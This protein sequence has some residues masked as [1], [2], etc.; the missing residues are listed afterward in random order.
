MHYLHVLVFINMK[1]KVALYRVFCYIQVHFKAGLTINLALALNL[2]EYLIKLK[3]N[4]NVA[5][6]DN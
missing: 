6:K 2:C 5:I 3:T 4:T 1:N